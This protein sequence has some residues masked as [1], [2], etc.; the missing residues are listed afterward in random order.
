VYGTTVKPSFT[1]EGAGVARTCFATSSA[2]SPYVGLLGGDEAFADEHVPVCRLLVASKQGA[3]LEQ[4]PR[5]R[6]ELCLSQVP[7]VIVDR[8]LVPAALVR[9]ERVGLGRDAGSRSSRRGGRLARVRIE[10]EASAERRPA[11][12]REVKPSRGSS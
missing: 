1:R 6:P 10:V 5:R 3:L 11:C 4:L 7:A 9:G 12:G 8:R 2:S